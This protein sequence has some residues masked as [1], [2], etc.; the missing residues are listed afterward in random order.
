MLGEFYACLDCLFFLQ[1][2]IICCRWSWVIGRMVRSRL[3][4]NIS[5]GLEHHCLEQ[6]CSFLLHKSCAELPSVMQ[7]PIRPA[8]PLLP[9]S[10]RK[11]TDECCEER[12]SFLSLR[13]MWVRL[14]HSM[15][16]WKAHF[17]TSPPQRSTEPC[18]LCSVWQIL[19][20][21]LSRSCALQ[22]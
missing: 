16:F 3:V 13:R 2:T 5:I 20:I 14:Q 9:I 1:F 12:W 19:H 21:W 17:E 8:H 10:G 18:F 7:Q 22:S 4:M 11:L 15:H 6:C